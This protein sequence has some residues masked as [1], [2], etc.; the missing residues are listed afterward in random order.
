MPSPRKGLSP[1]VVFPLVA[2]CPKYPLEG[3]VPTGCPS[4]WKGLSPLVAKGLSPTSYP[5]VAKGLSPTS[6]DDPM[7][8]QTLH[9]TRLGAERPP[10]DNQPKVIT[11]PTFSYVSREFREISVK[12]ALGANGVHY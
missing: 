3:S 6:Y 7:W 1:L 8:G 4:V 12:G 5:L 2:G 10:C 9:A 11:M